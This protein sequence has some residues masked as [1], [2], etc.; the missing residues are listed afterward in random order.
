[1]KKASLNKDL[2]SILQQ[3]RAFDHK[4]S[5]YIDLA[6]DL[7]HP[8]DMDDAD[9]RYKI[10]DFTHPSIH[11]ERFKYEVLRIEDEFIDEERRKNDFSYN[12]LMVEIV[13]NHFTKSRIED[14]YILVEKSKEKEKDK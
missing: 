5:I 13:S 7:Y 2:N 8:I 11:D 12:K 1:M 3:S 10:F 14:S 9:Y 6:H 4:R